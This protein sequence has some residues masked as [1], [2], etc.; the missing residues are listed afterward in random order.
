MT[1]SKTVLITG[2]TGFLGRR[3]CD[4]YRRKSWTVRAVAR[5]TD[6]YPF[7]EPGI[8]LFKCDLPDEVDP[9]AFSGADVV[10]HCAYTTRLNSIEEAH[11]VNHV[12]TMRVYEL[13]RRADVGRFVF[14]SSVGAHAEAESYYG[15]SKYELE[16]LMD[17]S[18][19]LIIRPGLIIGPG[20]DGTF[21]RMKAQLEKLG[22][23]P[24]FD[25]GH[26]I[27]Q[28][29]HIEDLCKAI[30]LAVEK[31][32]TGTLVVAEPEGLE[33]KEFFKLLA[34]GMDTRCILVPLPM[35]LTLGM[36]RI[37]E[38]LHLPFPLSS[39]NLLGLKQMKHRPSERDLARIGIQ[40]RSAEESL[41]SVL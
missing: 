10:I 17:P 39:E 25:G 33:M 37:I 2:A 27:L 21:N 35:T 5:R 6:A 24:I 7:S 18:K 15:R 9:S 20:E 3:L 41:S 28:T 11:Q 1:N 36:I 22:V 19:D 29:I 32:L 38:K 12:G 23:V 30:D 8:A 16:K 40:V 14:I 26:Q 13:S 31:R 34:A 4:Y